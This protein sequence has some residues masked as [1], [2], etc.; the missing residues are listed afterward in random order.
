MCPYKE[1][2]KNQICDE[3]YLD[4]QIAFRFNKERGKA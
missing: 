2:T 4:E 1:C 3:C